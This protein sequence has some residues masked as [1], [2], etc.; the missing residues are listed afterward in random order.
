M[1]HRM[2]HHDP[3]AALEATRRLEEVQARVVLPGHGPA[4]HLPVAEAVNQLRS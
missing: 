3:A 2:F 1:L 4:L